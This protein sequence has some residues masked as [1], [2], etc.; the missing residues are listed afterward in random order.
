MP[1]KLGDGDPPFIFISHAGQNENEL[2]DALLKGA[3]D[4]D[5]AIIKKFHVSPAFSFSVYGSLQYLNP[6]DAENL[7]LESYREFNALRHHFFQRLFQAASDHN[8]AIITDGDCGALYEGDVPVTPKIATTFGHVRTDFKYKLGDKV[9]LIGLNGCHLKACQNETNHI[10]IC[11]DTL[12]PENYNFRLTMEQFLFQD[13]TRLPEEYDQL[14]DTELGTL[15]H[16]TLFHLP[17][18]QLLVGGNMEHFNKMTNL[19]TTR[20]WAAKKSI[21][22]V[23]TPLSL[24]TTLAG[25]ITSYFQLKNNNKSADEIY[26]ELYETNFVQN[27]ELIN[28]EKYKYAVDTLDKHQTMLIPIC[29]LQSSH[30]DERIAD[31]KLLIE[32]VEQ[33]MTEQLKCIIEDIKQKEKEMKSAKMTKRERRLVRSVSTSRIASYLLPAMKIWEMSNKM[34]VEKIIFEVKVPGDCL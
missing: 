34:L 31:D 13:I 8:G 25:F 15:F 12:L 6:N 26:N 17:I 10:M 20:G 9:P 14:D 2:W 3:N 21:V 23:C 24:K 11:N 22:C 18:I 32:A 28:K 19:L 7:D 1:Q 30:R 5:A 16:A 27:S 29:M 4:T 33:V